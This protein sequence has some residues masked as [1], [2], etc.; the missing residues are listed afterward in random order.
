M[1]FELTEEQKILRKSVADFVDAEVVP[2]AAEL[3]EKA[4]FP[5]ALFKRMG[6]LGFYSLRY[7]EEIGGAGADSLTY[8]IMVEEIARGSMAVAATCAMQSLMGTNF[9]HRF[10]SE[11]QKKRLLL[12]ALKGEKI[13]TFGMTEANAGSDIQ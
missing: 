4:Q 2:V 8:C 6:E 3:D 7:P 12:P 13:G 9:L 5:H 11:E 10:G 1:D